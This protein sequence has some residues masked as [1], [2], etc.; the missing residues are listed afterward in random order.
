[1]AMKRGDKLMLDDVKGL[2]SA[3]WTEGY[4]PPPIGVMVI[5]GQWGVTGSN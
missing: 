4:N 1:M 2:H 5:D 3:N